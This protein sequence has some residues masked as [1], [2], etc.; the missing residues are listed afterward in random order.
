MSIIVNRNIAFL[1]SLQ[2][3]NN[4]RDTVTSSLKLEDF[5]H[6]ISEFG[7]DKTENQKEKMHILTNR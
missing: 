3:S 4:A 7:V 5:R 1:D 6:L 2:L